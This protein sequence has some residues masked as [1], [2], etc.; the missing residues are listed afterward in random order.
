MGVVGTET[1]FVMAVA[2]APSTPVPLLRGEVWSVSVGLWGRQILARILRLLPRTITISTSVATT[3][4]RTATV[5]PIT[6][7][8]LLGGSSVVATRTHTGGSHSL[9]GRGLLL[10]STSLTEKGPMVDLP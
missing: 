7:E 10:P 4:T 6:V 9:K 1:H 2:T 3:R 5:A 8:L